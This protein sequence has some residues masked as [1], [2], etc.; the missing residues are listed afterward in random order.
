MSLIE[1]VLIIITARGGSKGIPNK[2]IKLLNN[3]PLIQYTIEAAREVVK[4][5]NICLSTDSTEIVEVARQLGLEVPFVRPSYLATDSANSY[6][7]ILHAVNYY[8]SIGK[9][10]E[11]IILL[12]PTSPFRKGFHIQEAYQL[13][14]NNIDMVVSVV[15]SKAN[16]YFNL[17]EESSEGMLRKVKEGNYIR[18]QDCPSCFLFNGAIYIINTD[19]LKRCDLNKFSNII[20]YTMDQKYSVDIDTKLD[21]EWSEFLIQTGVL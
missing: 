8:E 17:W 2:N 3:K 7:T 21:W 5:E 1:N 19:S 9:F 10:F 18:R 14:N 6:D 16:P 11:T 4:D 13:Y 12:Q 20:K 15:E